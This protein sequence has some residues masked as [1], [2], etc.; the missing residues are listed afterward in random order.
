MNKKNI[1]ALVW[2]TTWCFVGMQSSCSSDEGDKTE[3]LPLPTITSI[4]PLK[5]EVG[6]AITIN[7]SN[8][9]ANAT[10]VTVDFNGIKATEIFF[11][12]VSQIS[13]Q[14]PAG[15][16]TG[17][18]SVTIANQT[19]KGPF[20]TVEEKVVINNDQTPVNFKIAFIGDSEVDAAADAVLS[21]IKSEG[22]NVVVHSGDLGYDRNAPL[23]FENNVN[24][25]LG[26]DFPYFYVVGNHDDHLWN[27]SG[28][29][30]QLLESRFK[31]L[32]IEWTGQLGV[33]S[34]FSYKG[35]FFVSSAPDEFG[36]TSTEAGNYIRDQLSGN[37]A[38]WRISFW[39]KNQRLMQIGGKAD[40]AGWD[41]Y[42]ESRKGGAI[43]AT[44]HEHSYSRTYEMSNF[45]TQTISTTNNTVNLIK[46]NLA[47]S[48]DE[49]R[50]FAFVSGLG[51]RSIRDGEAGLD[52]NPWWADVYHSNNGGQYGA[53]FGE[54][55]YNGDAMLAR[56]YFKDIDG[57]ER[58][59][60]FVRSNL[61]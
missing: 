40:E 27:I 4:N 13:T 47:T 35:I 31:R 16:T 1:Y 17:N 19:V 48:D 33:M 32:G 21:L 2:I 12:S 25:V 30:Q 36:I 42:E 7:G 24:A 26:E 59:E 3:E 38:I 29:Y 6:D 54:F 46:D 51:G 60:F 34:S 5:G 50:S 22:T 9:S 55:N 23:I 8:F 44:A 20:F 37:S 53:L 61:Q 11:S 43:I 45:Q 57:A 39:H 49:G 10:E 14:V 41:V 58:D 28:G 15:A 56:F 52:L 18:I